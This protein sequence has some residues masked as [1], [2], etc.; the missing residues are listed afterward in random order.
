MPDDFTIGVEEEFFLVDVESRRLRPVA[1]DVLPGAEAGDEG[2]VGPELQQCQVETGTGVCRTLDEVAEEVACLRRSASAAAREVG[3][4]LASSGSH[5]LGFDEESSQVTP[6]PAYLRL[7]RDYRL[8][9]HEQLVSGC[10]VHVGI[11]DPEVAVHVVNRVRTWLP[12]LLALTGNSP[13]WQGADSGYAS[14][15]TVVWQR[16]PTSGT[17]GTFRSRAEYDELVETLLDVGAIDDPARIYWEIRP[18]AKFDTVEFRVADANLTVDESVMTAGLVRALV[19]ACHRQV[20]DGTEWADPRAELRRAA[21]W[22]AARFGLDGRLIDLEGCGSLPAADMVERLLAFVQA[23][24]VDH[25]DWE[26]VRDLVTHVVA[27]G[28][29]A[30]RQRRAF[31]RRHRLEDVVDLVLAETAAGI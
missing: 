19:V 24:L 26:R 6:K 13:F 27:G 1:A 3:C 2:E 9:T 21:T 28:T 25:G 17:P 14:F 31:R 5:A 30:A 18:S 23:P 8:V 20:L 22:R 16:W 10:H 11:A 15:R 4:G 7:E 12:T 29:G